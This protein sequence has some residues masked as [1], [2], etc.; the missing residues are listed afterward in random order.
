M[1]DISNN[2]KTIAKTSAA[3]FGGSPTV[4]CYWDEDKSN[5]IDLLSCNDRPQGGVVSYATIGLSD[6]ALLKDGIDIGVRTEIVGAC[7][8]SCTAFANI[9]STAAFCV[10]NS[11]WYCAHG[12]VFPDIVSTYKCSSTMEHLFFVSP[13][14]WEDEFKTLELDSK[15]VAWLMAIPISEAEYQIVESKGSDHLEDLFEEKQI[16]IFDINRPSV[17]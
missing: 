16:D 3:V 11:K 14:L 12:V 17:V 5:S 1:P 15:T 4:T 2:N 7:A 13:F 10:I 6:Y 9:I 8:S